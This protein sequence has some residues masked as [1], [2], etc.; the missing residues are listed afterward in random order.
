MGDA[1]C[2]RR[3]KGK[4]ASVNDLNAGK[5]RRQSDYEY[6]NSPKNIGMYTVC[7]KGTCKVVMEI[8]ICERKGPSVR[9][10]RL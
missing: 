7:R 8:H 1:C 6:A 9:Y 5:K 10:A 4:N 3:E 2:V